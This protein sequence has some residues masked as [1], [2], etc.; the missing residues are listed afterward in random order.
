MFHTILIANRGEIARRIIRTCR[1]LGVQTVAVYSQADAD[2]AFVR[3]ADRA[4]L[5]G[6]AAAADSYLRG[7]RI[8][9]VAI[10]TGAQAIHPGYGFLSENAAF[11]EACEAAGLT[12]IGPRPDAI[13]AMALKGAAKALMTAA[14]VPVTPG[15]HGEDQSLETLQAEAGR[16]GYPVLIKAV[17]GGGGKGMR[18]VDDPAEFAD[19]LISAQREGL[20]AF[21]DPKVLIEKYLEIPRHIEIQLFADE[22]GHVVHLF[23]RDCS[24]Q[25]RHQ[26]VIEEAPAPDLPDAMR[27]AMGA[28]AVRAAQAIHY[29]GAGTVEFIV[30]VS[31]G[32]AD[33]P[34]YFMEMN[35]RLQVEHPVTE[36]ITGLDLVEW[37]LRVAAGEPLPKRQD[38]LTISGHAIEARLYAEDPQNDFLPATGKL[39]RLRFPPWARIESAVGEGDTVSVFYDPMIAKI[40]VHGRDRK[41]ALSRMRDALIETQLSGLATNLGFLRR[42]VSDDAFAAA[43]IDTGFI[44]RHLDR[45]LAPWPDAEIPAYVRAADPGS[46]WNDMT[47]WLVNLP[48]RAPLNLKAEAGEAAIA[49]GDI[50]AP[51]PGKLIDVFVSAGDSVEKGQKLLILGA[52]KIEHTMKA[53]KAGVIKAVHAAAGDQV[54][55][56]ALLVEIE[57]RP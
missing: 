3:E 17:A 13:R 47:G 20:N 48:P 42:L 8:I 34:F 10:E 22:H 25:R 46:P 2:A 35:T 30:D 12:F 50:N 9:A 19:A 51:M 43:H 41:Q 28:A 32:I 45:L 39:D 16:I 27:A 7:D 21:S 40:I 53:P 38:E 4:V 31:R 23:E 11:A 14:G 56:K 15:Y 29:R 33:A 1:R 36:E 18:R 24:L 52:M 26:K 5:I 6:P 44:G 37:Q 57:D 49:S 54:G 55:D